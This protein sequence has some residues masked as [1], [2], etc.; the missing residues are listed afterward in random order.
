[1][2]LKVLIKKG[3]YIEQRNAE[4]YTPLHIAASNGHSD[5]VQFLIDSG[6]TDQITSIHKFHIKNL[7]WS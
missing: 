5:I 3:A 7:N 2:E 4:Y 1:M 6:N